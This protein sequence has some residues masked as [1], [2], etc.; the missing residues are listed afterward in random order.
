MLSVEEAIELVLEQC[1]LGAAL[2]MP[3]GDA[4]GLRLAK[5]V[6]SELDSPPF[7]KSMM[8]GYAAR[9]ADLRRLPAALN[10]IGELAA[11]TE[12]QGVVGPGQAVQIMTGAPIPSGA[13]CV[14][15][16]EDT[17]RLGE[18]V[19]IRSFDGTAGT[20]VIPRGLMMRSGERV[21]SAGTPLRAQEL[22]V[23]AELGHAEALVR[24]RPRAAV[25]A[26]GDELVAPG[27]P[28]GA[29]QIRNS[30]ETMLVAQLRSWGAECIGLGIARDKLEDL[31]SRILEGLQRDILILTGGVSMG[32]KDLV[33]QVLSA[34]GARE[35]FHKVRVKPGKP[36]WFGVRKRPDAT[37][38]TAG[39]ASHTLIFALP[40]NP[41]SSMVCSELFVRPA[42]RA[43]S[44]DPAPHAA[45]DQARLTRRFEFRDERPTCFP[46]WI[47][48]RMEGRFVTPVDWK[49]SADLR[50]TMAANGMIAFP[51]G[52]RTYSEGEAV[53]VLRWNH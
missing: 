40:G 17:Q 47:E 30:N 31:Q 27:S 7:D 14:V 29:G 10:V 41:V 23:L 20:H 9:A 21:L 51:A 32:T 48:E 3:L 5:D 42:V 15:R 4:A 8:D 26:T 52:E 33:P 12:F 34:V 53:S 25:L 24:S 49:G 46:A 44:G 50:G 18:K 43:L 13:D 39:D 16:V 36:V 22:A 37:D 45:P 1:R 38:G 6:C 19:Q 11:G 35:V 28:L 2:Q